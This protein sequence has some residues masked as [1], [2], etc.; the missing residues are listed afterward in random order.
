MCNLSNGTAFNDLKWPLTRISRSQ[1]FLKSNIRNMARLKD[2]VTIAQ[3]ES[4]P[5]TWND[6]MFDDLDWPLN[7]SRGFVSISWASCYIQYESQYIY[8]AIFDLYH[9]LSR[10]YFYSKFGTLFTRIFCGSDVIPIASL[11]P[12]IAFFC[13]RDALHS[14][15]FAVVQCLSVRLSVTRRYCL[16]G[17]TYLK[18]FLTIW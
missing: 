8:F 9:R 12:V 1:H 10:M 17:K 2:K 15:V 18:T 7:A 14:T 11:Y 4:V 16:N 3:E 5:N 6:T 13:P